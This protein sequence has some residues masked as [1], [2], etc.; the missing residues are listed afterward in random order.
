MAAHKVTPPHGTR[1]RYEH[2]DLE[3]RCR[4]ACCRAAHAAYH[5]AYRAIA[6]T[7]NP[8]G[9]RQMR[10]PLDRDRTRLQRP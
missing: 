8:N 6:A 4:E 5:R 3:I 2:R 10:L 1:A 7:R 9:R